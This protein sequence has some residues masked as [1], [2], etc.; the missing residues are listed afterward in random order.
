MRK[1]QLR[2]LEDETGVSGTGIVT[3][4]YCY[5]SSGV[6][7]MRWLTG[8]SSIAFYRSIEDVEIIHGHGGKTVVEW[9]ETIDMLEA[10]EWVTNPMEYFRT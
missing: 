1:F 4:G 10:P 2:R 7:V 9:L 8:T 3:E 6:C 5:R